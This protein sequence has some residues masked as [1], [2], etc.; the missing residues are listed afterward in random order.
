MRNKEGRD[1]ATHNIYNPASDYPHGLEPDIKRLDESPPTPPAAAI[2][3]DR[4]W[5]ASGA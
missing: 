2:Q 1:E 3:P 4:D 5:T